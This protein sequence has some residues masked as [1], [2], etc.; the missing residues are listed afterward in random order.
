[1]R[2]YAVLFFLVGN[3]LL[4]SQQ[5]AL[6]VV[7]PVE[8][9]AASSYACEAPEDI[10][11]AITQAGRGG[12]ESLVTKYP[13]DFW[14]QRAYIDSMRGASGAVADSLSSE[15][16][17]RYDAR[18]DDPEAAY[19]YA[20]TLINK[21]TAKTIEILTSL[22][23]GTSTLPFAW[24]TLANLHGYP[25]F[26]DQAKQRTYLEGF[27]KRCPDTIDPWVASMALQLDRSDALITY[28]KALRER[29]AGGA[30]TQ[31]LSLYSNLWQL[32]SKTTPGADQ[33][34]F[35]KQVEEDLKFLEGL[36]KNKFPAAGSLLARGYAL[37]GNQEAQR[38][39]STPA[40]QQPMSS[41]QWFSQAQYEWSKENPIPPATADPIT[42]TAYYRKQLQFL[43]EWGAKVPDSLQLLS[44]R[45]FVLASIP[46]TPDQ[47]LVH[48]GDQVLALMRKSSAALGSGTFLGVLRTWA[49]RGLELDRVPALVEESLAAQEKTP[50]S[51]VQMQQSD[52]Y[53]ESYYTLITENRRWP[54]KTG[55]WGVLV[56]AYSKNRQFDEARGVLS[57]WEAALDERHKRADETRIKRTAEM[58]AASA[59]GRSGQASSPISSMEDSLVSGI[60]NDESRY[61]EGL[62]QLASGEGR[63]LDALAFYQTSL[64]LMYGRYSTLPNFADMEAG[65][66]AG[67]LWSELGGSEP[68]WQAWLESIRTTPTPRPTSA[69][70]ASA[71]NR[72]IPEFKL[73]DRSGNT[74]TLASL[75]GKTTLINVWAT[76]CGPCREEL[77]HLQQLYEQVR[78][79]GDVQVITLNVDENLSLVEPYLKENKYTFPSLFAKSFVEAFAGPIPIPTTWTSDALG[80][81]RLEALGFGGDG[82]Q[83]VTQKL[84]QMESIRD[85]QD[86]ASAVPK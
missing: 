81:I 73:S 10:R 35:R 82:S 6:P 43:D 9:R 84:K 27:L 1:M 19:L 78:N 61:H 38:K 64:R 16:K 36:D 31:T 25:N 24:R 44:S 72:P 40:Q 21:G 41:S 42:R 65:K 74:W 4:F 12:I 58:R 79:R 66:Q 53:G 13:G 15:F 34:Q 62:A 39:L 76:W 54:T 17:S 80:T 37:T 52:L 14:V 46:D 48:E 86:Q 29:I 32:E 28:T 51:T 30:D 55:A 59:A 69:P 8:D 7:R 5:G 49:E 18:P 67:R 75:K 71:V 22:T 45:F 26:Y 77:P 50:V 47:V 57:E 11:V 2:N 3:G 20:Y 60:P 23:Q 56:T 33:P 70:R 83:W 68:G 85:R 63:K